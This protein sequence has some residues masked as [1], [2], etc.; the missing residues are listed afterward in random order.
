MFKFITKSLRTG[1]VTEDRPFDVRPPFGFPVIDFARC[2]ACEECAKACPTG[3]I[4]TS[5]AA[6][7]LRTLALSYAACIQCRA[8]VDGCPDQVVSAG[9]NSEIAAYS[10]DQLEQRALYDVDPSTGTCTFRQ[11]EV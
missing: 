8:C 10:R 5:E 2:T 11:M 4:R 9:R 7:G 3:A 1:I 6:P